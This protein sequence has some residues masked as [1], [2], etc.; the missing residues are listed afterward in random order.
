MRYFISRPGTDQWRPPAAG[1][2]RLLLDPV[3]RAG[4]LRGVRKLY[5]SPDGILNY[6]PFAALPRSDHPGS[7]FLIQD[8]VLAYVPTAAVLRPQP[9]DPRDGPALA[10]APALAHLRWSQP[11]AR[12]VAQFFPGDARLLTGRGA[13]ETAFKQL[14][15]EYDVLH[16]A[17]DGY[18]NRYAPLL[19]SLQ[20]E[21]DSKNDG[22]LE[23]YEILQLKLH[24]SLVTLSACE[25]ALG[26]GY[27][28][29]IPA[30]DEFVGLTRAFLSAGAQ[31][32]AATLWKVNDRST[33]DFMEQFYRDREKAG[34]ATALSLAQRDM[35]TKPGP[36]NHPYYWAPFVLV[37]K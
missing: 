34:N 14:A 13:T 24:A 35:A 5:I 1:L 22:R 6:V 10:M 25:T 17:T 3:E 11:E 29:Q 9:G 28:S 37:G 15:G 23:V 7:R 2:R 32:V 4:W 12:E 30:G 8:Y 19:S 31:S 18:L 20:L 33:L 27:F 26:S 16:L 21:P 36:Y